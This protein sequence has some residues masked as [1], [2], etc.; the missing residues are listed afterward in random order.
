MDAVK[1]WLVIDPL[2]TLFFRGNE[3]MV[4]GESHE[5]RSIF[6]PMPSTFMGALRTAIL[7]QRGIKP[8]HFVMRGGPSPSILDDFPLL[9]TPDKPGFEVLGP[10]FRVD[11]DPANRRWIYPAPAHWFVAEMDNLS[12]S[13]EVAVC[14]A[15]QLPQGAK[16]LGFAGTVSDVAWVV[17]PLA[18]DMKSLSGLWVTAETLKHGQEHPFQL[19]LCEDL[20]DLNTLRPDSCALISSDLLAGTEIRFGIALE[21]STRKVKHGHLYSASHYRLAPKV[22]MAVGLSEPLVPDYLDPEG[23]VQLGGELRVARYQLEAEGP[24]RIDGD[25]P[26]IMALSPVPST[27]LARNGWDAHP[28]VSGRLLRIGGWDMMQRFHKPTKGYFPTGTVVR[29]DASEEVPFGFIRL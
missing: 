12:E 18:V 4:A 21:S 19:N 1:Q 5:V 11:L 22:G 14:V 24:T 8:E 2:D 25:S 17:N 23:I 29:V 26:W 10:I 27:E 7:Q 15:G 6:P 28:R 3:P 16:E 9:G 20:N 13:R